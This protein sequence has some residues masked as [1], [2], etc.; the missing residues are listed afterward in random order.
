VLV[1]PNGTNAFFDTVDLGTNTT[2]PVGQTVQWNWA[3][4]SNFHST[5]SGNCSGGLCSP[6]FIWDS[7]VQDEPFSFTHTFNTVGTF[8]YYCQ[9]HGVMMQGAV[10]VIGPAAR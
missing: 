9:V 10:N 7:G 6:D 4:G 1:G 3:S 5:T 2:I 8:G